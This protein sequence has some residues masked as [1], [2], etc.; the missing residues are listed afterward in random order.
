[1]VGV[2]ACAQV[3]GLRTAGVAFAAI[4]ALLALLAAIRVVRPAEAPT[5]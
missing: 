1:V 4:V 5:P 3:L 2:G